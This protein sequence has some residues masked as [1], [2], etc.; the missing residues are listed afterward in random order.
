MTLSPYNLALG[1]EGGTRGSRWVL[2]G[3]KA[4]NFVFDL[5]GDREL[6]LTHECDSDPTRPNVVKRVNMGPG[7]LIGDMR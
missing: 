1:L 5:A 3:F 2:V 6:T 4:L 7:R